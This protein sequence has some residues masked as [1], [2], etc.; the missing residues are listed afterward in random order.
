M[1]KWLNNIKDIVKRLSVYIFQ[2]GIFDFIRARVR[3][4]KVF[5]LCYHEI[6]P[7]QFESHL[8]ILTTRFTPIALSHLRDVML[9]R[10]ATT[11]LP[12]NAVL[13]TFDDGWKSNYDL[14]PLIR[15]F[16][17]PVTIFLAAGLIGT[18]R[19]IWNYA[20]FPERGGRGMS[21]EEIALN[22][23]LKNMPNKEKDAY[24]KESFGHYPEKEYQDRDFLS[25]QEVRQM[26]PWVDFQSHGMFHLKFTKCEDHEIETELHESRRIIEEL[27]GRECY[28]LA[29]P[30]GP[31][32]QREVSLAASAGYSISRKFG[33]PVMT[34][35]ATCS[36][37]EVIRFGIP[38]EFFDNGLMHFLTYVELRTLLLSIKTFFTSFTRQQGA[39]SY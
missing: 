39:H 8:E 25:F 13:I 3:S 6:T 26:S 11:P 37:M 29:Y 17:C 16:A 34:D 38:E 20:I 2:A 4:G 33:W 14:L 5:V 31:A 22:N 19:K 10:A 24:I 9:G 36:P 23:R 35:P 12:E 28:A 15:R 18:N 21:D 7:A 27:T 32:G 1:Y 30:Y